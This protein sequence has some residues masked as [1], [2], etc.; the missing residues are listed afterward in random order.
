MEQ[1]AQT[2]QE[3]FNTILPKKFKPEKAA[4]V[5]ATAQLHISGPEGGDWAVTIRN[6]KIEVKEGTIPSPQL[7]LKMSLP[8]FMDMVNGK[9]SA[10]KAFFTGKVQFNGN[11]ALA[12]KLKDAG[13][14]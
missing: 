14:L 10:E 2:P 13:F 4:G 11:I 7:T 8:D 1:Q 6:Q 9:L 5:D 12:L 3:F